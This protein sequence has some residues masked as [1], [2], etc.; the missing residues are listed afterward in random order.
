MLTLVPT[1]P[2]YLDVQTALTSSHRLAILNQCARCSRV[3]V[4]VPVRLDLRVIPSLSRLVM[5]NDLAELL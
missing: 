4:I 2:Q 3:E 1:E 5:V